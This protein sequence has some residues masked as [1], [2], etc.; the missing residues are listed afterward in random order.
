MA[1]MARSSRANCRAAPALARRAASRSPPREASSSRTSATRSSVSATRPA[2]RARRAWRSLCDAMSIWVLPKR[3]RR[4]QH[5]RVLPRSQD[6]EHRRRTRRG[7]GLERAPVRPVERELAIRVAGGEEPL[8]KEAVVARAAQKPV[9]D[10]RVAALRPPAHVVDVH[11]AAVA[12]GE[13]AAPTVPHADRTA[14]GRAPLLRL[15]AQVQWLSVL[16][17]LHHRA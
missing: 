4:N 17:R 11:P 10:I 7:V 2:R 9:A 15:P 13:P 6:P 3:P 1:D 8:V 14:L 5:H 12:A 16:K